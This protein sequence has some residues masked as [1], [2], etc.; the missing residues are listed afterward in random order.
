MPNIPRT[1]SFQY[2]YNIYL[3]KNV[4]NEVDSF[5][6]KKRQRFIQNNIINLDG[7][8]QE[9]PKLPKTKI[10]L[11]FCNIF[12]EKRLIKFILCMQINMKPYYNLTA[13]FWWGWLR[14][15]NVCKITSFQCLDN[16]SKKRLEMKLIS[17]MQIII[18]VSYKMI[19]TL[20]QSLLQADISIIDWHDQ[21]FSKY[22]K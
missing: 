6:A 10:L 3:K 19:S 11:F 21:A 5:T 1:T 22:S 12:R 9:L 2:L 20:C 18:K 4:K 8:A 13:W 15:S 14:I 17:W 16:I 7:C